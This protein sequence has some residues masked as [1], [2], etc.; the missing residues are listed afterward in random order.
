[1][2]KV[3]NETKKYF[4]KPCRFPP[5]GRFYLIATSIKTSRKSHAIARWC[6]LIARRAL[7][8]EH[9]VHHLANGSLVTVT[10]LPIAFDNG[11]D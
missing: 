3:K 6:V 4:Q 2:E 1:M 5:V 11:L 9:L 8:R 7:F 10:K